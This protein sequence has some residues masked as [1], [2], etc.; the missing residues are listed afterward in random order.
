MFLEYR[1][2][3]CHLASLDCV[4]K[5]LKFIIRI[6]VITI[7]YNTVAILVQILIIAVFSTL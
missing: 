6:L 7:L 1:G 4:V 3:M 5:V 2:K